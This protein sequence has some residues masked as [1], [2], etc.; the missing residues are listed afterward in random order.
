MSQPWLQ[1]FTFP[2]QSHCCKFNV[3]LHFDCISSFSRS[4]LLL[5][6]YNVNLHKFSK[7][8]K[9]YLQ[10]PNLA[11][12]TG[13]RGIHSWHK[14]NCNGTH[15]WNK[16]NCCRALLIS[17]LRNSFLHLSWDEKRHTF[18]DKPY[19]CTYRWVGSFV[20]HNDNLITIVFIHTT[21]NK[22]IIKRSLQTSYTISR[23][24]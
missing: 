11:S 10:S 7:R 6:S 20:V 2:L 18:Y 17:S 16:N 8:A 24:W 22:L 21:T 4:V 14:N 9:T 19:T 5:H 15:S 3:Q 23:F 1:G 12:N 13:P